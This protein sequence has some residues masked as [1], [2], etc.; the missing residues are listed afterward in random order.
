MRSLLEPSV[1][2]LLAL[3]LLG[4][5]EPG[6]SEIRAGSAPRLGVQALTEHADL[7]LEGRVLRTTSTRRHGRIETDALIAC[8]RTHVGENRSNR[9]ITLPGGVLP[10]G[11]GMLLAGVPSLAEGERVMLFLSESNAAGVRMPVGLSQGKW[12]VHEDAL[13]NRWVAPT[14]SSG[15]SFVGEG[16][17][18]RVHAYAEFLAKIE[19]GR[20]ARRR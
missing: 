10:N 3:L 11:D 7:V 20:H 2:V 17:D 5:G 14:R 16:Q 6:T 9:W 12:Y 1:L 8:D 13:G 19:V 4:G 18:A 15:V